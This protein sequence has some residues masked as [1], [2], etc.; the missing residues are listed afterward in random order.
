MAAF[1]NQNSGWLSRG[2][3]QCVSSFDLIMRESG[4]INA[5]F[6]FDDRFISIISH[7]NHIWYLVNQAIML[8][9]SRNF[10]V[11]STANDE[12]WLF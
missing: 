9:W 4:T 7:L 11:E 12:F 10:G 6:S 2:H 3:L 5:F 8:A 1:W